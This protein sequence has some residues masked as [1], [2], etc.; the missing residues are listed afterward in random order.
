MRYLLALFFVSTVSFGQQKEQ[1]GRYQI[2]QIASLT[3]K[4][5]SSNVWYQSTGAEKD[6]M[7][8]DT[9]TGKTWIL[10]TYI[11]KQLPASAIVYGHRWSPVSFTQEASDSP[12]DE[13][14]KK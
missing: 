2:I 12:P 1:N 5:A 6:V 9:Q 14:Y 13:K 11:A 10:T 4:P 8:L 7:L 3:E